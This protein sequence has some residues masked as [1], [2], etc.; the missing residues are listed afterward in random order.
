MLLKKDE[1]VILPCVHYI[2]NLKSCRW[3]LQRFWNILYASEWESNEKRHCWAQLGPNR[4][5]LWQTAFAA[6][7]PWT[8]SGR[9]KMAISRDETTL[10]WR[11]S[12]S[13]SLKPPVAIT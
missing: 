5:G 8:G 6:C 4:R 11:N 3:N 9:A 2:A 10:S 12:L 13:L 1:R 7:S